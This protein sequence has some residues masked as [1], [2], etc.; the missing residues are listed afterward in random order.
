MRH[1]GVLEDPDSAVDGYFRQCAMTVNVTELA[2]A[3]LFLANAG[4]DPITRNRLLSTGDNRTIVAL[5]A[6]CG[7]YDEV[8][9]FAVRVGIPAKSGVSGAILGVIPGRMTIA[10]YGPALG[11]VGNSM[12]GMTMLE[13][14]MNRLSL[15]VFEPR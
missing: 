6:T 13:V 4:E 14:I 3:G 12:A 15:S 10:C 8:G 9:R 7:L 1:F 5:M 2:R 11:P